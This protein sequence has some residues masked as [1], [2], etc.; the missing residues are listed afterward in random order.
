M[1]ALNMGRLA[2]WLRTNVADF[3]GDLQ[4]EPLTGGQSNPTFRLS[5]GAYRWVLR[6]KPIGTLLASAHAIDREFRVMQAL[7]G[8]D[9]PVPR[10]HALCMDA[11][12]I[13]S[14]FYV[15]DYIDGRIFIDPSLPGMAPAQRT[16]VYAELQR[17]AAAIHK[18]D[19]QP[20]GLSDFGRP[21]N[22]LSRQIDRWVRQYRA[23]ETEHI[24][25]MEQLI[26]W[27]CSQ[28][29]QEGSSGLIHGDF[30]IDNVIFHPTEPRA[31]AVIDWELSTLGNPEADFAYHCM[32][33]RVT[34]QE[35][36]GLKGYDIASLGIPDEAEHLA[37]WCRLTGRAKP[38]NWEFLLAFNMFRMAAILQGILAR[39]RLGNAA[40]ADAE[41]TGQRA[42]RMAEAG[43]RIAQRQIED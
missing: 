32:A 42:R 19:V 7:A 35:F 17:V 21:Q 41:Q 25:A 29:L 13:G 28:P 34:P 2:S 31:L 18:V 11:S 16:A 3:E 39:A 22:Y 26:A 30:R 5:A 1:N 6:C 27:L 23:S 14:S 4:A 15:M 20:I 24:E 10:M 37:A 9:V 12:V 43:W 38:A 8:T 40:A 36:R 33:W